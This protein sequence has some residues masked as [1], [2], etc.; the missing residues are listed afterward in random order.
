MIDE[1]MPQVESSSL[2]NKEK[3]SDEEEEKSEINEQIDE[4]KQDKRTKSQIQ[5]EI[6]GLESQAKELES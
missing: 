4:I 6:E 5:A 2:V 1:S 3:D